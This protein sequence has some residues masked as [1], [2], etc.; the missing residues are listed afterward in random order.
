M[1]IAGI[2]L[3]L[4]AASASAQHTPL[5]LGTI[6]PQ[7]IVK[8]QT[9]PL[10]YYP[11]MTCYTGQ[12]E[13]CPNT[14]SLGFTYGSL[15]PAQDPPA[16]TIVFLEGEGGTVAYTDPVYA[17]KYLQ[18]GFQVVYLGWDTDWEFTGNNTGTSIKNAACRPATF[19]QYAYQN[20]YTNGGMCVQGASAGAGAVA[21]ALAWYGLATII[22]N[23]E[24]L[25]GPV[26]GDVKQGC[27]VPRASSVNVCATNQYGCNGDQWS[28]DPTYIDG[29]QTLVGQWSG[30]PSCND[31][32]QT[33]ASANAAWK[34]MSIVDGSNNANFSYPQTS[35]A[36]WLC[37]NINSVQN[38]SSAQGEFFYQ[39][40]THN[41]QT[42][43]YSVTRINFC[44][45]VE[46]VTQGQTPEG[47]SGFIA[48]SDHMV[49]SCVKRH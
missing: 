45:G 39:Q 1:L 33:S 43:G 21:Y 15:N 23:V 25:S 49:S 17:Q 27:I 22:D 5:Q 44:D 13:A 37:S 38:N 12:V 3:T 26:F 40:F 2:G 42:A 16:G 30:Q 19:L 4:S 18:Q 24:M 11:G 31:G 35:M 36:A 41:G 9:C 14:V 7:T 8:L 20:V 34:K 32:Q 47:E 28:D 29:D 46:G 6:N 48:I 10:G